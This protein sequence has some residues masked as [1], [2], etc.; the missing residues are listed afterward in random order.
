VSV[1]LLGLAIG[2][3]VAIVNLVFCGSK[4]GSKKESAR[5]NIF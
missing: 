4:E 2:G 3:K 1:G 5:S